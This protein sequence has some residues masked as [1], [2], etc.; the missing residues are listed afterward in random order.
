MGTT[1]R[2][3]FLDFT[4]MGKNFIGL[5]N[6]FIDYVPFYNKFRT[7]ASILVIA[8]FCI[9]LLAALTIKELIQKPETLKNNM[10]YL[11]IGLGL[12]GASL[13][14]LHLHR[15]SF[16]LRSSRVVRCKLC[17]HFPGTFSCHC[18]QSHRN[19]YSHVYRRCVAECCHHSHW[20]SPTL[21][22]GKS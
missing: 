2:D 15:N 10:K 16:S 7:V 13:C 8:E 22:Y 6:F 12:T 18:G 20:N 9:P 19:A 5:T 21:C 17:K 3:Y 1:C 4:F 11:Y 14:C